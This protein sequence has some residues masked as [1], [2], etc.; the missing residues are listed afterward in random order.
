MSVR[1]L[2][3]PELPDLALSVRQP[4]A[5]AIVHG[6]KDIENRSASAIRL[7]QMRPARIA[8][9]AAAG[10]T[11]FEWDQA[12]A[13]MARLG[14]EP[15][16]AA[17]LPRGAVVGAATVTAIVRASASPWFFGPRGL[18]LADPEAC[19]PVPASGLLGF[20]AWR[21]RRTD[22]VRSAARWMAPKP[23]KAFPAPQADLFGGAP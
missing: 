5:W 3:A 13:I 4:W 7:G 21:G 11:R 18:S 6:G 10:L 16:P 8:I 1:S 23:A 15:P 12:V 14:V 2:I 17:E 19:E 20:F 9:H 22:A